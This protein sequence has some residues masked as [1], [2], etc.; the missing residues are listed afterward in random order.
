MLE[1]QEVYSAIP[2]EGYIRRFRMPA[3]LGVRLLRQILRWPLYSV[4]WR[5]NS[6]A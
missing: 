5:A 1:K 2:T 3:L 6:P 4:V